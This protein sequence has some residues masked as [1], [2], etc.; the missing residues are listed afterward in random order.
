MPDSWV[1]YVRPGFWHELKSLPGHKRRAV[2]DFATTLKSDPR[3][4]GTKPLSQEISTDEARRWRS[5]SLRVPD[6]INDEAR[7]VALT[8]VRERP[9]YEYG[10]L[11]TLLG[12]T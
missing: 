2:E 4:P 9:P 10:D 6:L 7:W 5:G 11:E 1:V 3:G 12:D 8:A